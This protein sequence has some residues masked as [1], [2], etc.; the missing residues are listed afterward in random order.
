MSPS[1]RDWLRQ[2]SP[3]PVTRR[4]SGRRATRCLVLLISMGGGVAGRYAPGWPWMVAGMLLPSKTTVG[5]VGLSPAPLGWT[6]HDPYDNSFWLT[7]ALPIGD[8]VPVVAVAPPGQPA[9]SQRR[10]RQ[11]AFGQDRP[12]LPVP[13]AVGVDRQ[14]DGAGEDSHAGQQ[15]RLPRSFMSGQVRED[16]PAPNRPLVS[17]RAWADSVTAM[18]RSAARSEHMARWRRNGSHGRLKPLRSLQTVRS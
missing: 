11:P 1:S 15:R 3:T 9:V 10:H 7:K 8:M 6:G 18:A 16:R 14:P 2:K 5:R 17:T 12:G 4:G 13:S